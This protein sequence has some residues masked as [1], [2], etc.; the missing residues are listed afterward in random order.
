MPVEILNFIVNANISQDSNNSEKVTQVAPTQED[1][2][3][4][5]KLLMEEVMENVFEIMAQ[6]NER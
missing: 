2:Q 4:E 5:L 1:K 3:E 6:N